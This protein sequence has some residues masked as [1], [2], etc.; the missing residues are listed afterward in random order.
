MLGSASLL[1]SHP[2]LG[3]SGA[4][5]SSTYDADLVP[6]PFDEL[7]ATKLDQALGE[8]RAYHQ[9]HGYHADN[10]ARRHT[11]HSVGRLA[12][13]ARPCAGILG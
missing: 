12:R 6:E 7:T 4:P 11:R 1:V 5:L 13:P 2:S 9:R 10:S 8:N 3:A